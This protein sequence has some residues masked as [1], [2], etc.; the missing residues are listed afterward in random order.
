ME[1]GDRMTCDEFHAAYEQMPGI[2]AELIDGR[3]FIDGCYNSFEG[4]FM[5]SPVSDRLHAQPHF[6]ICTWAGNYVLATPGVEGGDNGSVRLDATASEVQPDCYLRIAPSLGG[7]SVADDKGPL[8]GPPEL[9]IE[10]AS[11]SRSR[12]LHD[13][14]A[15]YQQSGVR[16]YLVIQPV[17]QLVE[18]FTLDQRGRYR[19]LIPIDGVLQSGVFPGLWLDSAA[20]LRGD[21]RKV[22]QVLNRGL[23]SPAHAAFVKQLKG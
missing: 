11:S 22:N 17:E 15:V 8:R 12:D 5:P 19:P 14:Y 23:K 9:V 4:R 16:E 7:A 2:R 18:W 21:H 6:A 13:K 20:F 3:V 1:S 10:V